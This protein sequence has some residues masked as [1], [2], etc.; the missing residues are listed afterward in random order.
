MLAAEL[1]ARIAAFGSWNQ[2]FK[3][4]N[5]VTTPVHGRTE[6]RFSRQEQR[7]R[8]FF[9]ALLHVTGGSLRGHRVL[10]IGSSA[11]FW[12]LQASEAEADFVL[13]V[14]GR[15]LH[16][17]QARLVF[18]ATGVD[19][20]RYR[21]DQG[22]IFEHRFTERFDVVLCLGF[23]YH[24]SKPV[25]LMELVSSLG[26]EI[27]VIDTNVFPAPSSFFRVRRENVEASWHAVDYEL[28]MVPTRQAVIDL[29]GQFGFKT[30]PLAVPAWG[31]TATEKEAMIDYREQRRLAFIAAKSA[32][33]AGLARETRP[34]L[35]T[36]ALPWVLRQTRR[37][38]KSRRR[39]SERAAAR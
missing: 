5:G 25:E 20:A 34:P 31:K 12:S 23:L 6:I 7:R 30:V 37:R 13:G 8:Y 26:A 33:L 32:S 28:V 10:D 14:D 11:G 35:T 36:A 1:E 24:V 3:F 2:E 22:N 18:E 27:L 15:Q 16:A 19:P 9:D 17:E 38:L 4:D 29:C 21:F 39:S